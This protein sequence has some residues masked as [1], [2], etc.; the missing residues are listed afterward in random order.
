MIHYF[1]NYIQRLNIYQNL[2]YIT[3]L[4]FILT[5]FFAQGQEI[6]Y[7]Y[8]HFLTKD[9][10]PNNY[11]NDIYQDSDGFIWLATRNDVCRYDGHNFIT[12]NTLL[13]N[14]EKIPYF[15]QYIFESTDGKL[16]VF[17]PLIFSY[18]FDGKDF[19]T[20]PN[21]H[22][23]AYPDNNGY[24]WFVN[25]SSLIKVDTNNIK[26]S[27][28]KINT[29]QLICKEKNNKKWAFD[30]FNFNQLSE[31]SNNKL[32]YFLFDNKQKYIVNSVY[33]D[34]KNT[35]WISTHKNGLI[36]FDSE[37][38]ELHKYTHQHNKNKGLLSNDVLNVFEADQSTMW[39]GTDKGINILNTDNN[40]FKYI[41]Q[42]L[43]NNNE[44]SNNRVTSIFIDNLGTLFVGT[45]FGLNILTEQR[46][47]HF[48]KSNKKNSILSNNV[49]GFIE[50]DLQNIWIIS[51]GGLDKYNPHTKEFKN[52]PVNTEEANSLKASPISI[53]AD[54]KDNFWIGTWQGGIYYFNTK[55]NNFKQYNI[56]YGSEIILGY[57]S[58]MSLFKDS[59]NNIWVG[60]WGKGL[61]KYDK[62]K[63]A[64]INKYFDTNIGL[65]NNE[66]ST[67]TQDKTGRLWVGTMHGL[68][69][70]NNDEH[71]SIKQFINNPNDSTSL[72]NNQI[73]S[74]FTINNYLWVGTAYGLNRIDLTTLNIEKFYMTDGLPSNMILAITN[75]NDGNLW[76][77]TDKGLAKI[78]IKTNRENKQLV[79]IFIIPKS[80]ELQSDNFKDRAI[81][82]TKVG[83]I[84]LGGSNGFNIFTPNIIIIDTVISKCVLT[85]FT[86]DDK[87]VLVGD[88]VFN[89]QILT[90]PISK[91]KNIT[92]SYKHNNFSLEF[93]GLNY[94]NF[95]EIRYKYMLKGF[96][97]NW[98]F[99]DSKN[100]IATYTNINKGEYEFIV[101]AGSKN[102]NVWNKK[103]LSLKIKVIPPWW[104]TIVFYIIATIF[105]LFIFVSFYKLRLRILKQQKKRLEDIVF[106]RT[107]QLNTTNAS[108]EK[109]HEEIEQ[110]NTILEESREETKQQNEELSEVNAKLEESHEEVR[111]QNENLSHLNHNLEENE[112]EISQQNNELLKHRNHLEEM[113]D[114]RTSELNIAKQKAE[115]SD[116]LKSAF[117]AN[118]SHE[119]RTPLNAIVG[120]SSLFKDTELTKEEIDQYVSIIINN[121]NSLSTIINDIIDISV[122]EAGQLKLTPSYFNVDEVMLELVSTYNLKNINNLKIEFVKDK[123]QKD[124]TIYT[125]EV[126]FRQVMT[127]ILNNACKFTQKGFIKFGY[128]SRNSN[129]KFF[130]HDS[131][132]GILLENKSDIF[133]YFQ[134]ISPTPD[135]FYSGT[136]LGLTICQE[137]VSKMG[138]EIWFESEKD[139]GTKFMF[140]IPHS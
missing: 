45:R 112:E 68:N 40:T 123:N 107:E 127:N 117:L 37:K 103:P 62:K 1:R 11:I 106:K 63:D 129:I 114:E 77:T 135:K 14:N 15:S 51:S 33:I 47:K 50:D 79:H 39:I 3:I 78:E 55:T 66:I 86:I 121:S 100:R 58:V 48:I 5:S 82:K 125:D 36:K 124:L 21:E 71:N 76:V 104:K 24:L 97:K 101:F 115:E 46:F 19:S 93:S 25:D 53:I 61:F 111:Q 9:G 120:F 12:Y 137:L 10:L 4:C 92:L 84:I 73:N 20:Y 94:S 28:N 41:T 91:T 89:K 64:F 108:L 90:K 136:G 122:I 96:D 134:K 7:N 81:F 130:V 60:S 22:V 133:K 42:N 72:S 38:E 118:M 31:A 110:Q 67:I 34:S 16:W 74:L 99:T 138:G 56:N 105:I 119:I 128:I 132:T 23:F 85:K 131:G 13:P 43:S 26:I 65:L 75:D 69:L 83:D 44:L 102:S 113:I 87:E 27:T 30:K 35:I 18:Y 140:T 8:K 32:A 59:N 70:F 49:H 57:N 139:K 29:L 80:Y 2:K 6:R 98:R 54:G 109:K 88:S 116:K 126:R 52:Y 17:G 95:D